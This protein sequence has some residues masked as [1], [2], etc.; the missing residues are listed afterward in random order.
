MSGLKSTSTGFGGAVEWGFPD[1]TPRFDMGGVSIQFA[2]TTY[3][4]HSVLL[5]IGAALSLRDKLD[6]LLEPPPPDNEGDEY[7]TRQLG[8]YIWVVTTKEYSPKLEYIDEGWYDDEWFACEFDP[9]R[10]IKRSAVI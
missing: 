8:D 9:P 10:N 1:A 3:E 7:V 5:T 4:T 2:P 6:A